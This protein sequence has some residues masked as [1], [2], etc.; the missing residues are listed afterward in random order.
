MR[1]R[2]IKQIKKVVVL[3]SSEATSREPYQKVYSSAN[4]VR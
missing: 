2:T 1:P 3:Y 4:Q